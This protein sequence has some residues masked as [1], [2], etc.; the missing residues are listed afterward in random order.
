MT[1]YTQITIVVPAETAQ[2][3]RDLAASLHP[4]GEGMFLTPLYSG[5]ELTH[6]ISTGKIDAVFTDVL[7]DPELFAQETGCS[8]EEAQ[9]LQDGITY[10][11][12]GEGG[13]EPP[14]HNHEAI[15]SLGLSLTPD[16]PVAE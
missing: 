15:Q 3:Y 9:G 16:D 1:T 2:T 6:Y 14:L 5:E 12:V 8:E 7:Q 13:E 4:A 10:I 11:A